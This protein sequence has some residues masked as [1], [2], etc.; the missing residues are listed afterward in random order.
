MMTKSKI[1]AGIILLT[2]AAALFFAGCSK[3]AANA[4]AGPAVDPRIVGSWKQTDEK[5]T[6]VETFSADG[7]Y[8][9][10]SPINPTVYTGKFEIKN[11]ELTIRVLDATGREMFTN[12][13]RLAALTDDAMTLEQPSG[14]KSFYRKQNQ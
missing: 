9:L 5:I 11:G 3:P 7:G 8:K 13:Y 2:L 12:K 14:V 4:P 1:H 10:T 6:S